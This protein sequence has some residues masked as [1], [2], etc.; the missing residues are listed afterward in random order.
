MADA[1]DDSLD[2][3]FADFAIDSDDELDDMDLM[4]TDP[5]SLQNSAVVDPSDDHAREREREREHEH[6]H[7]ND[8]NSTHIIGN[9]HQ[10]DN[11]SSANTA[12]PSSPFSTARTVNANTN[13][14]N[15]ATTT[16]PTNGGIHISSA[17]KKKNV[18]A[19]EDPLS[20]AWSNTNA[21]A[22]NAN[23][24]AVPLPL[25]YPSA[26]HT[27]H[28]THLPTVANANVNTASAFP[29]SAA[30]PSQTAS[31][32]DFANIGHSFSST[33]SSFA[34]KFQDVVASA[35]KVAHTPTPPTH[36][37]AP[38]VSNVNNY[39]ER[40]GAVGIGTP[41]SMSVNPNYANQGMVKNNDVPTIYSAAQNMNINVNVVMEQNQ[42]HPQEMDKT[43][44]S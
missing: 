25:P 31:Q 40:S 12:E 3:L 22:S 37:V 15:N 10:S 44:K 20:R 35:A 36:S 41:A 23:A 5:L 28:T 8:G 1:F 27:S 2:S 29:P 16:T 33:F 38:M 11:T 19:I 34:S 43:R 39:A 21:N 7:G 14:T 13:T 6:E 26:G 30:Y 17:L 24:T 32:N 9:A 4:N 42:N 18:S